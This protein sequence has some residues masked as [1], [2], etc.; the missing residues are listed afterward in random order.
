MLGG[1][2]WQCQRLEFRV[3]ASASGVN[4]G[5]GY[6][7]TAKIESFYCPNALATALGLRVALVSRSVGFPGGGPSGNWEV[8]HS[9]IISAS[10]TGTG[11]NG[12]LSGSIE[13]D[14]FQIINNPTNWQMKWSAVRAYANGSLVASSG[15]GVYTSARYAADA[16]FPHGIPPFIEGGAG[17]GATP[18]IN[19]SCPPGTWGGTISPGECTAAITGGWRFKDMN[20]DWQTPTVTLPPGWAPPFTV[21]ASTTWDAEIDA[22]ASVPGNGDYITES[23][24]LWLI[25]NLPRQVVRMN[26][27]YEA[28]ILRLAS[29]SRTFFT[30]DQTTEFCPDPVEPTVIDNSTSTVVTPAR[31]TL[32]ARVTDI[33][34][35]IEES[36]SDPCYAGAV[37]SRYFQDWSLPGVISKGQALGG[38]AAGTGALSHTDQYARAANYHGAPHWLYSL[39][40]PPDTAS[41]S[42]RWSVNGTPADL[43]DYWYPVRQQWIYHP[44]IPSGDQT[45]RRVDVIGEGLDQSGITNA[46]AIV[47]GAAA[48]WGLS[49]FVVD[50]TAWLEEILLDD[51][52]DTRWTFDGT[53]VRQVTSSRIEFSADSIEAEFDLSSYASWPYMVPTLARRVELSG[54]NWSNVASV[55]IEIED[56][57]G[58][59]VQLVGA[60]TAAG[61][62]NIPAVLSEKWH[63]SLIQN[64]GSTTFLDDT[65]DDVAP[66]A[67]DYSTTIIG[68]QTLAPNQHGSL[69]RSFGKLRITIT[70]TNPANPAT[71]G[72]ITLKLAPRVDWHIRNESGHGATVLSE[73]GPLFRLSTL[74]FWN[75]FTDALL[76]DPLTQESLTRAPTIGDW[77]SFRRAF[78]EG[79]DAQDGILTEGLSYFINNEEMTIAKHLWRD[80][81][82]ILVV[83]AFLAEGAA[84]PVP[85]LVNGYRQIPPTAITP[86]KARTKAGGWKEIGA[87]GQYSYSLIANKRN[88]ITSRDNADLHLRRPSD[89]LTFETSPPEGWT[90]GFHR[91]SVEN[92]EGYDSSIVVGGTEYLKMRPWRGALIFDHVTATEASGVWNLQTRDG[93]FLVSWSAADGCYVRWWSF[94]LP[95]GENLV[96]QIRIGEGFEQCRVYEDHRNRIFALTGRNES[97][98]LTAERQF[99]DDGGKTWSTP[100]DMGITNGRFPTGASSE[101]GDQIEAAFVHD[102]GTSGPGTIKVVKRSSGDTAFSSPITVKDDAGSPIAFDD[103]SF[104]IL[105]SHDSASRVILTAVVDGETESS[106]W[107]S[108]DVMSGGC[109]FKRFT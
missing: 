86:R 10:T 108:T 67:A 12:S 55:K 60:A 7:Y 87:L 99:S 22:Y 101:Y 25:P 52:S 68:D 64:L 72:L 13:I 84:G 46:A 45:K 24:S 20:G 82:Q 80:P 73:N 14:D 8:V 76:S 94:H 50:E 2:V 95:K 23:G 83:H 104:G 38:A 92:D 48:F 62:W 27:D 33:A 63:T 9:G 41:T 109:T 106:S 26:D 74:A 35:V 40:L 16:I 100:T 18:P 21:N 19:N 42:V 85:C 49:E 93:R 29:P 91:L 89:I 98:T 70:K 39:W 79:R 34:N 30:T 5:T 59:I 58:K 54:T 77:L 78:L 97:G 44:S 107:W 56:A 17:V 75:A 28:M 53:G 69:A 65:Y 61:G 90:V 105:F 103:Q 4:N 96:V 102:S 71:L 1:L 36:L 47:S 66:A 15:A 32:L 57:T 88:L 6:A 3:D 11:F 51:R 43:G 81:S 31:S 37:W